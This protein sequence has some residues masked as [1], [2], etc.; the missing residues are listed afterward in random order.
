MLSRVK[1]AALALV[2]LTLPLAGCG[3]SKQASA[4]KAATTAQAA[5]PPARTYHSRP[6]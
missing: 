1:L 6:T 3:H 4:V 5:P 2:V